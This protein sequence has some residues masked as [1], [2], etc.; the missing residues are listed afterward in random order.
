MSNNVDDENEWCEKSLNVDTPES[1]ESPLIVEI[2]SFDV[3][4]YKTDKQYLHRFN[5]DLRRLMMLLLIQIV[6][7]FDRLT[8]NNRYHYDEKLYHKMF[9]KDH[10]IVSNNKFSL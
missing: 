7:R 8:V 10:H 6:C 4:Y 5:K 2:V 1:M 9:L 3:I